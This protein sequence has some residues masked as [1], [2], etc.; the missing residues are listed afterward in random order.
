M[1]LIKN[2]SNIVNNNYQGSF[3]IV[4]N[5]SSNQSDIFEFVEPSVRSV[6]EGY[7]W[8]IMAYGQTG[9]GKTYTMFGKSMIFFLKFR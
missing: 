9:S 4:Y 5:H 7:N 3:D 2:I 8:S 1:I 6:I